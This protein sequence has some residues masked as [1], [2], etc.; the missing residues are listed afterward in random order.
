MGVCDDLL[1]MDA[2]IPILGVCLGHQAIAYAF[3]GTIV[4]STEPTHGRISRVDHNGCGLF[5]GLPDELDV[6]RYHSLVVTDKPLREIEL[7]AWTTNKNGER[8]VMG[9]HHVSKPL[10]GVQFHPESVCTEHGVQLMA[11]F[12]HLTTL[13]RRS[14]V[15]DK[16]P[17]HVLEMSVLRTM[18]LVRQPTLHLEARLLT[19]HKLPNTTGTE[20]IDIFEALYGHDDTAM[21]LDSSR[22]GDAS[23]T[24]SYMAGARYT[25]QYTCSTKTVCLDGRE[26]VCADGFFPWF[27]RH[28]QSYQHYPTMACLEDGTRVALETLPFAFHGGF[29][30]YVGY[31]LSQETLPGYHGAH[32]SNQIDAAFAYVNRLVILDRQEQGGYRVWLC[33]L[34]EPGEWMQRTKRVIMGLQSTPTKTPTRPFHRIAASTV[35]QQTYMD[36]VEACRRYI[37]QG[38]AYQLCLTT[39]HQLA[40]NALISNL[41]MYRYLQRQNPAPFSA[42]LQLHPNLCILSSSP[43]RFMCVERSRR[44]WM[45]PIKG[46][47]PRSSDPAEDER[48]RVWLQNDE[49]ERAENLMIV[50]L[51]RHD[52]AHVCTPSTVKVDKLMHVESYQ[53]VHQLVTTVS[54]QLDQANALDA[55][56]Q[57]FPPGS[58]T[59]AP[60]LRSVQL[61][62][63]IEQAPRGVYSGVLGWISADG[64][65]CDMSVVIRTLVKQHGQLSMGAGGAVTWLSTAQG[66]WDEMMLKLAS[67]G[68]L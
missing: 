11:N 28:I 20:S 6:V 25:F 23:S 12:M 39:Q 14:S 19:V 50:D 21:W 3:G 30:G 56:Q 62:E 43:E 55:L 67:I 54:G 13:T 63:S 40:F 9:L 8:V 61:L 5:A 2:S 66:E 7:T 64:R 29:V 48:Q 31:E 47:A 16:L 24:I 58:M 17:A 42:F 46:T 65:A 57:C 15:R 26:M 49:K 10:Y 22:L 45:K 18:P 33:G 36:Q 1:A 53:T 4:E 41:D 32:Y 51:I 68:L 27:Q 34:D 35:K 59:G 60:K 37:Q 52:L 44:V 38:E